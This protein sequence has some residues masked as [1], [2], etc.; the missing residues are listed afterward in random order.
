MADL[1]KRGT[2]GSSID[3]RAKAGIDPEYETTREGP[4]PWSVSAYRRA[5]DLGA[6]AV[7]V[8]IDEI[9]QRDHG[10]CYLC[11]QPVPRTEI[12]IDHIIPLTLGGSHT[13][14]N[15][16]LTHRSCN[17]RK[18]STLTDKRPAALR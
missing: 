8:R 9:L 5:R 3:A 2:H 10:T 13:P 7:L 4:T 12:S 6:E 1:V 11:G 14:A 18:G 16:G 17:A 15:L